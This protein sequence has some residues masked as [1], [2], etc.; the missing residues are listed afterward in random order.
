MP[1]LKF[2]TGAVWYDDLNEREGAPPLVILR[3]LARSSSYW[4]G[5]EKELAR[6][7]RV[8]TMDLRGLGKTTRPW[9]WTD[10]I[11]DVTDD[12][13]AVLDAVEL[14]SAHI[15]GVSLGGMVTLAAGLK[16]PQ[17]FRSLTV[18]NTSIGG[19]LWPLRLT[20]G[21]VAAILTAFGPLKSGFQK[22]L[23]DVLVGGGMTAE[24]RAE[25]QAKHEEIE[26]AEGL[27]VRTVPRQLISAM[28]FLPAQSLKELRVPTQVVCGGDDRFVP[29]QNS[30][31]VASLI[32]GA[33]FVE[34]AGGGHEL[35]LDAPDEL[36]R[37]LRDFVAEVDARGA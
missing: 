5:Y 10:A 23:V 14:E 20:P 18:I 30:R 6:H 19:H 34:I 32:P 29:N 21:A 35:M 24:R 37:V 9:G 8:V 25:V 15:C 12:V 36:A 16:H 13:V 27:G 17:R 22:R 7:F 4:L 28:R 1:T 26:R 11:E 3:G 33:R 31:R 2:P